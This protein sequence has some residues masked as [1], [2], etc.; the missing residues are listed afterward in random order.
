MEVQLSEETQRLLEARMKEG[1]FESADDLIRLALSSMSDDDPIAGFSSEEVR[2]LFRAGEESLKLDGGRPL[3]E[4]M[5]D[6]RAK[7]SLQPHS[8]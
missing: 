8:T 2:E 3:D 4:V 1:G 5:R 6:L 7:S